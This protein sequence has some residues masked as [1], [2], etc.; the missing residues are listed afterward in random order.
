MS[1]LIQDL[2]YAAR[3]LRNSPGF[4]A[5]VVLT[6]ALGIG[7]NTT[8]F[9][10]ANAVLLRALPYHEPDR[11][12]LLWSFDRE[13]P[14][15]Q[16]SFTDI[17]D[18]RTQSRSFEN[19]VSF[20]D[21]N[22]VFSDSGTPERIAGMQVGEGYLSLMR[23][24]PLLGRDFLPEE[25]IEGKDQVVILS[26]GLW[27]RRFGSDREIVGRSIT[28][29]GRPYIVVG[30]TPKDFPALPP[31]LVSNGAQF[32]RPEA[33]KRDDNER[34]SRHLRAIA[35][36]KPA[37]S[38]ETAQS[39]LNVINQR[40]AKL[41]PR[42]YA[43]TGVRVVKLQDDIAGN[44]R[45]ALL[46]LIGAVGFLLLIACANVAN[47]LLARSAARQREVAVRTALGASRLRLVRQALTEGL[48][49]ALGGGTLSVL[50]AAWV[51]SLTAVVGVKVI[52]QLLGVRI[53]SR[54][55]G[56][57]AGISLLTG[58]VFGLAPALHASALDVNETLKEGAKG[59]RGTRHGVVGKVLVVSEI[60][61]SLMLLAGAG[62]L[63]RTL[64]KLN[65]VYPG[66]RSQNVL[67][68]SIG[69]PS[70]TYPEGSAKSVSFYRDLLDQ[71]SALPGVQSAAAVSILPLGGDFDT[72]ATEVGGRDYGPGEEPYP[73]RYRVTPG[74][75]RTL[76]IELV[77]GRTFSAADTAESPLVVVVSETAAA[78][79]WPHEDPIGK[80]VR[81]PA[82]MDKIWRTVVGV[83]RDVKQS[84]LDAPRTMQIYVPH[85]Q[86][87]SD[88]MA[89]VVRTGQH[90][91]D[92]TA[93]IRR[94]IS[95]LDKNLAVSDVATLDE[96]V[97]DSMASRRFSAILLGSFA[98]LGLLLASLGVYG[99][100]SYSVSRRTAEIGIR[101][102]LGAVPNDVLLLILKLGL[103]QTL[104]GVAVGTAAALALTRLMS[105]LLFE[106]SPADP[107][108]FVGSASLLAA[109]AS[110]A[111]YIPARRAAGV[112]P[113]VALRDE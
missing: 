46:V 2:R 13:N 80:R 79:W 90:P 74:Y 34:L 81:L 29:S 47:L 78:R 66:F 33:D 6:L 88:F 22:A 54:V 110:M 31:S 20:G 113:M 10:V 73:E 62:L 16:L 82:G 99:I 83:V 100:L 72:V 38:F 56:F 97:S 25:Q 9:S 76:E 107:V 15:G 21:W 49:L 98:G 77:G 35:R 63:V 32:Y 27:Q 36:L 65:D 57:T 52:P 40:M 18:Y 87:G 55:L 37:V 95:A 48:L 111:G 75:F 19:V 109:V 23:V 91:L 59:S 112:D 28:L 5:V 67:S 106:V 103:R 51:T 4:T 89:L 39:E 71:V 43:S 85:A 105:G 61:L 68:M 42:D 17:D 104:L 24:K 69:L 101:M 93:E 3:Q 45:S 41:F 8:I 44:L 92:Y 1:G 26:Y 64:G 60:A 12:A 94:R 102:A 53:D 11:L 50:L 96:V 58:I 108:V 70:V 14:R 84:G 86:S 7:A 30:V